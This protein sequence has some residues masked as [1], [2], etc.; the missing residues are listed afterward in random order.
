MQR[1][2]FYL[3][4]R[5]PTFVVSDLIAT[6][7]N[8]NIPMEF[9]DKS[10]KIGVSPDCF[11]TVLLFHTDED[12]RLFTASSIV[13]KYSIKLICDAEKFDEIIEFTNTYEHS[14]NDGTYRISFDTYGKKI[15]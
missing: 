9:E 7:K 11:F 8:L 12:A 5:N 10:L 6:S 2:C 4:F 3:S 1:Y 15:S 14:I 13:T